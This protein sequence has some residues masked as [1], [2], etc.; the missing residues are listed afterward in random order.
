MRCLQHLLIL[1]VLGCWSAAHASDLP[2]L[3]HD[4]R[5]TPDLATATLQVEDTVTV[6]PTLRLAGQFQFRL[7]KAFQLDTPATP[8]AE[9]YSIPLAPT[10]TEITLKYHGKLASTPDC[11]WLTQA[12]VLLNERG[13]YLDGNSGWYA[14]PANALH[15]FNL[16]ITLPQGWVSLSQG[17]N[18]AEGWQ[19]MQPQDSIYLI[20]GQFHVYQEQGKHAIALVYLQQA[21]P[22]LAQRYLKATHQYLDEYSQLLGAYPYA[23]FATVESFWETGWGMPSFTLLGARVMRLPFILHTSFPHEILH[24]WWGNGVYVD[25]SAGNW[26][27]GL[28]AYLADH[29]LKEKQ[30]AGAEYRRNTLQQ[31]AT[32][33]GEHDD[34][35]LSQ[36]RSRHDATTQAVGYGKSLM[37]FHMLRQQR[38]DAAFFAGLKAFYR[39]YRGRNASFNQ[40]LD[41]LQADA[42]FREQWLTRSGAPQLRL[43][44]P[45]LS[46]PANGYQL[47]LTVQQSQSGAPFK[48]RVPLRIRFADPQHAEQREWLNLTQTTQTFS[49][50]LPAKP[51]QVALDPE[52]DVFRLADA[53]ELP[54]TLGVLGTP[55]EKTYVIARKADASLQQAWQAWLE[56]LKARN[57]GLKVQYDDAPLPTSGTVVLL[58]GDNAALQGIVERAKQPFRLTD[59]AYTLNS[60]NYTCGLHSLALALRAGTQTLILLDASTPSGWEQL[61][62]KLPHYSQYSYVVLNSVS[63]ENVAKGQWEVSDSPLML[64]F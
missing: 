40:L 41:S 16:K 61:M 31:Y 36:F 42:T 64:N 30:G 26:S 23:K 13:L 46:A 2:V 54:A 34:F 60:V 38:G 10:Q 28:T 4:L 21:D 15:T 48:L 17:K 8:T 59:A 11:A 63:G 58:G 37:L 49:F 7:A 62:N 25:S 56:T 24:N 5:V 20:A 39:D 12:C 45:K 6:P 51:A 47:Q 33:V 52:F 44:E 53:A 9:G 35:P 32:F 55:S 3:H 27:E 43:A 14:Q 1:L 29:Y 22:D 50:D 57:P 19:E 18:T